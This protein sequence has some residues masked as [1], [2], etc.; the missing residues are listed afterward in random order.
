[1]NEF[2]QFLI[3]S[4]P[5]FL[6]QLVTPTLVLSGIWFLFQ[7]VFKLG[8]IKTKFDSLQKSVEDLSKKSSS[9][10]NNVTVIKTHLVDR[11]G[12]DAQLFQTMS[13]I[14]LTSTGKKLIDE[15]GFSVYVKKH[16]EQLKKI[17]LEN[18]ADTLLKV[19]ELSESHVLDLFEKGEFPSYD[20]EAFQ[21][22]ITLEV[23]LRG[24]ALYLRNHIAKEL[25]IAQ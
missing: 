10:I 21:R 16:N 3:E 23:L 15:I 8:G 1:M 18:K 14:T 11:S 5:N 22:G 19:D 7:Y 24:C 4:A 9:I 17:F 12:I 2:E 20:N 13:P 25:E 6:S